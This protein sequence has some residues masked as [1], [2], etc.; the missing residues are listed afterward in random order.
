MS[1]IIVP[2]VMI[3]RHRINFSISATPVDSRDVLH[4]N[5]SCSIKGFDLLIVVKNLS[6]TFYNPLSCKSCIKLLTW[7]LLA[8][9]KREGRVKSGDKHFMLQWIKWLNYG[10][11]G[12]PRGI[13][14]DFMPLGTIK[15]R[16]RDLI[17]RSVQLLL[18]IK[19]SVDWRSPLDIWYPFTVASLRAKR[20]RV[21]SHE[22]NPLSG[23]SGI[24]YL[25]LFQRPLAQGR[26]LMLLAGLCVCS[27]V[28]NG[29]VRTS[30]AGSS[31]SKCLDRHQGA[32][33]IPAIKDVESIS[34]RI[35]K[36]SQYL[37]NQRTEF[38]KKIPE[39]Y[40]A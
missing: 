10:I 7:T 24:M 2:P 29:F 39:N 31:H 5:F 9:I 27:T 21:G 36:I 6:C 18:I 37:Q 16:K 40:S 30:V 22:A 33:E 17:K 4:G 28:N 8:G 38:L 1:K 13:K 34:F 25:S 11:K 20:R 19:R 23:M 32:F 35:S 3:T 14:A 12:I 15:S 26:H